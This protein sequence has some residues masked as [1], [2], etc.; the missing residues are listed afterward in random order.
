MHLDS[1]HDDSPWSDGAY[2]IVTTRSRGENRAYEENQ[3][4][5]PLVVGGLG[6]AGASRS[7]STRLSGDLFVFSVRTPKLERSDRGMQSERTAK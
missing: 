7:W 3:F 6:C 1:V 4:G 5:I 2:A